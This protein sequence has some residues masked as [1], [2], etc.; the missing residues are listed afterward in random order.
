MLSM[1]T[2]NF[3]N[4]D[5]IIYEEELNAEIMYYF[6]CIITVYINQLIKKFIYI[7]YDIV[8]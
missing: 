4:E 3:V 5:D 7:L 6:I 2:A 1:D 8:E